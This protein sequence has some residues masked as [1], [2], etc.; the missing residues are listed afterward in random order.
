MTQREMISEMMRNWERSNNPDSRFYEQD[1]SSYF[2]YISQ[3]DK[4][5]LKEKHSNSCALASKSFDHMVKREVRKMDAAGMFNV[6]NM[7]AENAL[8]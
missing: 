8:D 4:K 6:R 2:R 5:T 1:R 7:T 3:M